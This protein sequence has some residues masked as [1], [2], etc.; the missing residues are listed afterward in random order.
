MSTLPRSTAGFFVSLKIRRL[1]P[2]TFLPCCALLMVAC[3]S[4]PPQE[5]NRTHLDAISVIAAQADP[6][7]APPPG[8]PVE[9]G[10]PNPQ[11]VAVPTALNL[12][13]VDLWARLRQGYA[14]PAVDMADTPMAA[15]IAAHV[16]WYQSHPAH[17]QRTFE[18]ARLYMFD[19]AQALEKEGMPLEIALLPAVESAFQTGVCS[20]AAACGLWQF[21]APTA[22]RFDLKQH[23]FVD[24]R[25]HIQAATKAAL[26]YLKELHL[27]FNGDW[28]LALAAYNCGEGCIE[29]AVR[30]AKAKGLPGRFE[31]LKL[32]DE[33]TQ[34]VPRLLAL[35]QVVANPQA[36]GL[37]L[38][39]LRN[40]PYFVG[41]PVTRDIDKALAAQLAGMNPMDF[42]AL[43]PQHK[44]PVIVAAT[45]PEL[46]VPAE[47]AA[48]FT[49][50]LLHH[51]G[52]LASWTAVKVNKS[53]SVAVLAQQH[54]VDAQQLRQVNDIGTNRM[55]LVGSTLLIPRIGDRQ[56]GDISAALAEQSTLATAPV[57]KEKPL[58]KKRGD[59][60]ATR[61]ANQKVNQKAKVKPRKRGVEYG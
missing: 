27:R 18:R 1:L 59:G 44:K 9:P 23:L 40:A 11:A 38:P 16:R 34:Y 45:N 58:K 2:T 6:A 12:P 32:V 50:A 46:F 31:D 13:P 7:P 21:I 8:T 51:R 35:A 41:V 43:N 10:L 26:R 19:I 29:A 60:K 49:E 4:A 3:Q 28:Q 5:A 56:H 22:R 48:R 52:P 24:D 61:N 30:R 39:E 54:Q 20:H 33:T 47:H 25:R 15:R 57:A 17:V 36:Y 55:V 53:G 37:A 14:L 42:Q